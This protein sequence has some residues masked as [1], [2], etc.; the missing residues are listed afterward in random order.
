MAD[1]V[2]SRQKAQKRAEQDLLELTNTLEERVE[3]RTEE[4]ALAN[5][6]KSQFLANMSHEIR[7]PMN[8]VL[9]ML[10]LLLEGE[11]SA[12]QRRFAQT[13]FRSG[14]SLLH[15]VNGILDLSKIEAG[16]L[17]LS[18]EPFNLPTM[19]E[20][21]VELFSGA[22]RA[23]HVNLAH[24]ISQEVPPSVIGDEGR[25]RQ[26]LTNILGNAV[27]FTTSGEVVLYVNVAG[28][29]GLPENDEDQ[30]RL[31]FK[32]RDTGIGIP[33]DKQAEIFDVF[34]QADETTTRRYGGTGLGLASRASFAS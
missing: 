31:E 24:M 9:G 27:K 8:G 13:A 10:E 7:T 17:Q 5:R 19:I 12:R 30:I 22:A 28:R 11:L 20:E 21:A 26:V 14:E 32:V 1:A 23:K 6:V 29:D 18:P 34:S 3:K 15:I 2:E 33:R 16:K 25:I 4:L